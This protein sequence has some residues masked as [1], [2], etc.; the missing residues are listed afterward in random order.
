M[1]LGIGVDMAEIPRMEKHVADSHFINK[2]YT[3]QEQELFAQAP[4]RA[5]ARMA[6]N[7]AVKEA[8]AKATGKGL[9]KCPPNQVSVLRND[10][11]APYVEAQGAAAKLLA[12]MGVTRVWVSITNT[13]AL[14]LAQVVLEGNV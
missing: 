1:I 13:D 14:A 2:L 3:A 10:D 6:G 4:A 5:A 7:F 9:A 12:D 8:L 11:G